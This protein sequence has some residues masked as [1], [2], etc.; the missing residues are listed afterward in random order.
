MSKRRLI[1][2]IK[3]ISA[4]VLITV[5]VVGIGSI[6]SKIWSY[7]RLPSEFH[8]STA[9]YHAVYGDNRERLE[10]LDE[11]AQDMGYEDFNDYRVRTW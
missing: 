10:I 3:R 9:A 1:K 4:M 11:K 5:M 8:S 7:M 6:I 2:G